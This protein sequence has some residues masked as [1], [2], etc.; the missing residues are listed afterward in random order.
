MLYSPGWPQTC[1][2]EVDLELTLLSPSLMLGL[3]ASLKR[4][5]L[6]TVELLIVFF[7][8]RAFSAHIVKDAISFYSEIVVKIGIEYVAGRAGPLLPSPLS[9]SPPPFYRKSFSF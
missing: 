2:A 5:A 6:I 9:C 8:S 4:E 1:V 3:Q 7:T